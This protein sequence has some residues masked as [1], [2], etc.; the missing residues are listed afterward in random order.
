L[1]E[2]GA[3]AADSLEDVEEESK[4]GSGSEEEG[5]EDEAKT[6]AKSKKVSLPKFLFALG[7][8]HVGEETADLI[9]NHFGSI[10]KIMRATLDGFDSIEGIGPIVSASVIDWFSNKHNR[11]LTDRLLSYIIII[12]KTEKIA[13]DQRFKEKIFVLTGTLSGM[14]RDEAK[15]KIKKY[16]GKVASSVSKNTNYVVAGTDPGSKYNDAQKLGVMIWNEKEFLDKLK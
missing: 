1:K 6:K 5:E 9:A 3:T 7:I 13:G 16:G 12:Q 10:Q 8:D 2:L 4:E 14:S 11:E 15:S